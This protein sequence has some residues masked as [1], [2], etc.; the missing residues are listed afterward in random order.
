MIWK[1]GL[2]VRGWENWHRWFA[3]YPVTVGETEDNHK[4][5]AWLCFVERKLTFYLPI[6]YI[7]TEYREIK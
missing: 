4:I 7:L 5:K 6:D 1:N 2:S 3:W